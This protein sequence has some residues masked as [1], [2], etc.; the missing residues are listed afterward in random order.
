MVDKISIWFDTQF[1]SEITL[2]HNLD[3]KLLLWEPVAS[4]FR[5]TV[6]SWVILK[7]YIIIY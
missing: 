2:P 7:R 6:L 5:L 4:P 1:L 3:L